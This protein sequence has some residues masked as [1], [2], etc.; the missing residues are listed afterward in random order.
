VER[1][2]GIPPDTFVKIDGLGVSNWCLVLGSRASD[3]AAPVPFISGLRGVDQ[4]CHIGPAGVDTPSH[5]EQ[6]VP[7]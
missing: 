6:R 3:V 7:L 2:F 1:V 4:T 5:I